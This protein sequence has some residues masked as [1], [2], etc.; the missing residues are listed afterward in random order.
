MEK[1]NPSQNVILMTLHLRLFGSI[2]PQQHLRSLR[3]KLWAYANMF[4][5]ISLVVL[6][7]TRAGARIAWGQSEDSD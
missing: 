2:F 5:L 3:S 7:L 6:C 1:K 4:A